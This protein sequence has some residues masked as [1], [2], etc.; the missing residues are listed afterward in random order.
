MMAE[1]TFLLSPEWHQAVVL[2]ILVATVIAFA[3]ERVTLEVTSLILLAVLMVWFRL[4][5]IDGPDGPTVIDEGLLLSGFANPS[6]LGVLALLVMGQA[7]VQTGALAGAT[8]LYRHVSRRRTV[9][10]V[11]SLGGVM[12]TSALLN[13]TPV[14]VMFIPIMQSIGHRLHASLSHLMMPLSFAAILGGM[15]TLIGSSTNMLVSSALVDLGHAPL[16]LF[17]MTAMGLALAAV[18]TLY[19]VFILPRLLPVRSDMAGDLLNDGK[20]FIAEITV[21]AGGRL[22][23]AESVAGQFRA[24]PDVTVRLIQRGETSLLPPYDH[25]SLQPGDILIVAATRQALTDALPRFSGAELI[26]KGDDDDDRTARQPGDRVFAEA[27]I[28]PASRMIDQTIDM[29]GFRRRFGCLVFGIQRRGR[30]SRRRVGD[31]RLEA[32]DVLLLAG[33]WANVDRLSHNPDLLL[34][35][36][37]RREL[38][39]LQRAPHAMAIFLG[40]VAVAALE[41]LP[42]TVA[43]IVG[44]ILHI[45]TGCLNLRQAIRALDR[46]IFILVGAT[47]AL[48]SAMQA[49]GASTLVART[50]IDLV[51]TSDPH[52]TLIALFAIV[53]VATN[54]IS[55]NACAILFTPIAVDLAMRLDFAPTAAAITVLLAANCSFATPIGYQT[56]LLV[57]GPGHYRFIDYV[58]GGGPL[59][60][61]IWAAFAVTSPLLLTI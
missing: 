1:P 51:G 15:T 7:L 40:A 47:L 61:L 23:G 9:A 60:V 30:M 2:A 16:G 44:A 58:R 39:H 46:T 20:Q 48:G 49:T 21:D 56:N 10:L 50:F 59:A 54:V 27:M 35:A 41:I 13:N 53:A 6:L 18:G 31:I 45:V 17:D 36:R 12:G 43:A 42:I 26:G 8:R 19:V 25:V 24:L 32:G 4:V 38:P 3:W 29:V 55:N 14:V 37:S 22:D 11:G 34:M 5:A 57:M 28:A 33:T 52:V